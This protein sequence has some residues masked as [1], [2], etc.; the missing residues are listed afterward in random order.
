MR[1][2]GPH[3]ADYRDG[4]RHIDCPMPKEEELEALGPVPACFSLVHRVGAQN[5]QDLI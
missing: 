5:T 1:R 3:Q 4:H 2:I